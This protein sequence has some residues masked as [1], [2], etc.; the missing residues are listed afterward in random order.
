MN[1]HLASVALAAALWAPA[2]AEAPPDFAVAAVL[3]EVLHSD[4][5]E[6]YYHAE[7]RPERRPVRIAKNDVLSQEFFMAKFGA[8]VAYVAEGAH[9]IF[10]RLD[11]RA[12]EADVAFRYLPEGVRGQMALR[13]VGSDWKI[14]RQSLVEE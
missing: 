12:N 8:P 3:E 1:S 9:L 7:Q 5:L 10:T 13:K 2:K 6:T 4:A 14:T 11:V